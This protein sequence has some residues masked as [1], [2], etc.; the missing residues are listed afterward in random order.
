MITQSNLKS[1]PK[2]QMFSR[3]NAIY[4]KENAK[5]NGQNPINQNEYFIFFFFN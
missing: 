4:K 3:N 2:D 5:L 1:M